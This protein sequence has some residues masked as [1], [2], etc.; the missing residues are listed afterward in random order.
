MCEDF[1][2]KKENPSHLTH[3]CSKLKLYIIPCN[4]ASVLEGELFSKARY[5]ET[6]GWLRECR[7]R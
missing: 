4:V 7:K 3:G 1:R 5:S 6:Y 2:V